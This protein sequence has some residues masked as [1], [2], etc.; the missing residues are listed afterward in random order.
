MENLNEKMDEQLKNRVE[1]LNRGND[2]NRD[3][4]LD[5]ADLKA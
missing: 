2:E 1:E 3:G 4:K 5:A